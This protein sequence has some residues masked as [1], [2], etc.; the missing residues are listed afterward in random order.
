MYRIGNKTKKGRDSSSNANNTDSP[1]AL[2]YRN[3]IARDTRTHPSGQT[4]IL[5]HPSLASVREWMFCRNIAKT[6]TVQ[7]V[8]ETGWTARWM[9]TPKGDAADMYISLFAFDSTS[10]EWMLDWLGME[11][12]LISWQEK[13][14][15][16]RKKQ[17]KNSYVNICC[18]TDLI[19]YFCHTWIPVTCFVDDFFPSLHLFSLAVLLLIS[20]GNS[21]FLI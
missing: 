15:T 18:W 3:T 17:K 8:R 14:K 6:Q 19:K 1:A 11:W 21:F 10:S 12:N 7:R 16:K 20:T 5:S 4:R 13:W 2:A 9:D